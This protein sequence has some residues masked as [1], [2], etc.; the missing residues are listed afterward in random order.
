MRRGLEPLEPLGVLSPV[1]GSH[2][3]LDWRGSAGADLALRSGLVVAETAVHMSDFD[4]RVDRLARSMSDE[5]GH[6]G[7]TRVLRLGPGRVQR[8][9]AYRDASSVAE[10]RLSPI[11]GDEEQPATVQLVVICPSIGPG[12]VV[13]ER[14]GH[15][16]RA[17]KRTGLNAEVQSGDAGFDREVYVTQHGVALS[18]VREMVSRVAAREALR[19]LVGAGFRLV[20][21]SGM[22]IPDA[23]HHNLLG[24]L[25]ALSDHE[26]RRLAGQ[27][28]DLASAWRDLRW[29][30]STDRALGV[31]L[32]TGIV[33][34]AVSAVFISL[35]PPRIGSL[36][37]HPAFVRG[38]VLAL[39]WTYALGLTQRRTGTGLGCATAAALLLS[40]PLFAPLF[41]FAFSSANA[42]L[43]RSVPSPVVVTVTPE[44]LVLEDDP[45]TV[46]NFEIST[47]VCRGTRG[48]V[49]PGEVQGL[50]ADP[51]R[52]VA[53]RVELTVRRGALGW[54]WISRARAAAW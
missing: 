54:C 16:E 19:A 12:S 23:S 48:K 46:L 10:L 40:L 17:G 30:G 5:V 36:D 42:L 44:R 53:T 21:R 20:A 33:L 41:T 15:V 7:A 38:V 32:V 45:Y 25:E 13:F 49:Q 50:G 6:D 11:A 14:E 35:E 31:V 1:H 52:A 24:R 51:S 27:L 43:D 18:T 47:G 8:G 26:R 29:T 39:V 22:L 9:A 28:G 37:G 3:I 2:R 4:E 34:A